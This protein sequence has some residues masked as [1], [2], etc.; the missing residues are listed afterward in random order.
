ME[1]EPEQLADEFI[2]RHR[3]ADELVFSPILKVPV[4][5]IYYSPWRKILKKANTERK[6]S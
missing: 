6:Q 4:E 1:K 2:E 5:A 3:D